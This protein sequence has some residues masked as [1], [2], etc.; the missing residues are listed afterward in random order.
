MPLPDGA[1]DAEPSFEAIDPSR[2]PTHT[3]GGAIVRRLAAGTEGGDAP[4]RFPAPLFLWDIELAPGARHHLPD[5][6]GERAVYVLRGAIE[7]AGARVDA[8]RVAL[9]REGPASVEAGEAG[10]PARL[11]AFG[12][13][14]PG[15]RYFWWNFLSSSLERLEEAKAAWREGRTPL[16]PGDTESFTPA[17]PDAARPLLRLNAAE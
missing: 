17:P 8:Q 6:I 9:L 16:P 12:G 7:L 10:G 14:P 5:G 3:E 4:V 15:P 1:E 2:V 11:L 13:A